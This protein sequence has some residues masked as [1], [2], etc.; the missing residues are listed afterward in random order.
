MLS[1]WETMS[2]SR[3]VLVQRL[4]L[5]KLWNKGSHRTCIKKQKKDN[6]TKVLNKGKVTSES[7]KRKCI[8]E[9]EQSDTLSEGE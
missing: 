2:P 8:K 6:Q 9:D 7:T 1:L 5:Q 4:R 3:G